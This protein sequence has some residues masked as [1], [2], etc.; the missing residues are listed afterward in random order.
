MFRS[1]VLTLLFVVFLAGFYALPVNRAWLHRIG[2]YYQQVPAQLAQR[3][4]EAKLAARHGVNY[5]ALQYIDERLRPDDV[6]LLPPPAY[7]R[8][9]FHPAYWN[10]AEPKFFY[11][12]L[13]RHP[14]VTLDSPALDRATATVL[15]GDG[16]LAFVRLSSPDERA[17]V[18]QHFNDAL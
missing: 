7:V 16:R 2:A 11:Y 5:Q 4:P 8:S 1:L 18:V 10:W 3:D 14:T 12:M 17:R 15:A 6:F 13:G 9:R